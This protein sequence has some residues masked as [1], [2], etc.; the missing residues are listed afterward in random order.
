MPLTLAELPIEIL[1][2][3]TSLLPPKDV[4]DALLWL[5]NRLLTSKL[6]NG[7]ITELKIDPLELYGARL[8]SRHISLAHSLP[9]RSMSLLR[10]DPSAQALVLGLRSTLRHLTAPIYASI[11]AELDPC[12]LPPFSR[13]SCAPWI[14]SATFPH[15]ESLHLSYGTHNVFL[16]NPISTLRFLVGLPSSLTALTLPPMH[17]F[18]YWRL[19]PPSLTELNGVGCLTFPPS[20][21]PA[22]LA[23]LTQIHIQPTN[24]N[25][26]AMTTTANWTCVSDLQDAALPPSLTSFTLKWLFKDF[27]PLAL[28]PNTLTSLS[29]KNLGSTDN[30]F[31]HPSAL[32]SVLPPNLTRLTAEKLRFGDFEGCH[33]PVAAAKLT[34][35]A[36]KYF[37]RDHTEEA[38]ILSYIVGCLP[39]VESLSLKREKHHNS[40]PLGLGAEHISHLNAQKLRFLKS[41]ILPSAFHRAEDGTY[42]LQR[43]TSLRTLIFF[44]QQGENAFFTF[45]AIPPSVTHL[46]TRN[47]YFSMQTLHLIP[48]SVTSIEGSLEAPATELLNPIFYHPLKAN[49]NASSPSSAPLHIPQEPHTFDFS[50]YFALNRIGADE[51]DETKSGRVLLESVANRGAPL[52]RSHK[53]VVR[54]MVPY[55][56]AFPSTLT[57]LDLLTMDV[58][59]VSASALPLLTHL[60]IGL[61]NVL[62]LSEFTNL[63]SLD[64]KKVTKDTLAGKL[65]PNLTRLIAST[66]KLSEEIL[67]LPLSLIEIDSR[68]G[69]GLLSALTP[70][71]NL[72]IF[73]LDPPLSSGLELFEAL[74]P[75][76]L[77]HLDLEHT[78]LRS[79]T[80]LPRSIWETFP[81]LETLVLRR[82][83]DI[84]TVDSLYRSMPPHA[85]IDVIEATSLLS[86]P[87]ELAKCSGTPLGSIFFDH[88]H[89]KFWCQ[90]MLL[91][92]YPRL[93][94]GHLISRIS[95]NRT[96]RPKKGNENNGYG[97]WAEFA[98]YLSPDLPRLFLKEVLIYPGFGSSL[99]RGL[100]ELSI[101]KQVASRLDPSDAFPPGLT[102]FNI[103]SLAVA[104]CH[105]GCLPRGLTILR[106]IHIAYFKPDSCPDW[107]PGLIELEMGFQ[108]PDDPRHQ[109]NLPHILR[110]LPLSL[111][112]LR[113]DSVTLE[114]PHLS[115]LPRGLKFIQMSIKDIAFETLREAG[116]TLLSGASRT[117]FDDFDFSPMLDL[118][119]QDSCRAPLADAPSYSDLRTE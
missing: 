72:Q 14:V 50:S 3:V 98:P 65:P 34:E 78:I 37:P 89:V 6:R 59:S 35:V 88:G 84:V 104:A 19:L 60:R 45:E 61:T 115:C 49:Q 94:R 111:I 109:E 38:S 26:H 16:T 116:L 85:S 99:P 44:N 1:D 103:D 27:K 9:L 23:S 8:S 12:P 90:D 96:W 33:T 100:K 119:L 95:W 51:G 25:L 56:T 28:L 67:P 73:K 68:K 11:E 32:F 76:S 101:Q 40:I 20:P 29:I 46:D 7:G 117:S 97:T 105:I 18:N 21:L 47:N 57:Y 54:V 113:I 69:F 77:K 83:H 106:N 58:D 62:D 87:S 71:V 93:N 102:S 41:S 86:T 66:I 108:H 118:A 52:P 10:P 74:P 64:I 112:K 107:P 53:P 80:L 43:L 36:L 92:T 2:Q 22:N 55:F 110:S 13:C 79:V 81:A 15:L 39:N 82:V 75:H 42:P 4:L 63:V 30:A 91:K 114:A 24:R 31:H 48:K 17:E 70:L 5:G